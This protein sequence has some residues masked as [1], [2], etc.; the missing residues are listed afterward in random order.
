M[1]ML[2]PDLNIGAGT[3]NMFKSTVNSLV[4]EEIMPVFN[5]D[6]DLFS[7]IG[8]IGIAPDEFKQGMEY[9]VASQ[10]GEL[11]K[12]FG[13][14]KYKKKISPEDRNILMLAGIATILGTAVGSKDL[15]DAAKTRMKAQTE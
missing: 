2:I 10:S 7:N 9:I 4:G 3:D 6:S 11:S 5:E 12:N 14:I 1:L 15:I 13:P 8:V